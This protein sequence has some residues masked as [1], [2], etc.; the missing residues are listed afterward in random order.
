MAQTPVH[1][2]VA[3][4]IAAIMLDNP[5]LNVLTVD[6][7]ARLDALLRE[8]E[9]DA[10]VKALVVHGAGERAFSAGSDIKEFDA[11]MAPN[12]A[13]ERKLY[14]ENAMYTRLARFPAPTIAAVTGI[15]FGGGLELAVCCDLIVAEANS[16]F[17]LPEVKLGVFPGSGGTVRV[18]RRIGPARAKEMIYFG[19]PIDAAT[20][21][22]WGLINRVAETGKALR[23]AM[24]MARRLA[25]GPESLRHAK[26]AIDMAF[27]MTEAD[28]VS[29]GLPLIDASF[30]SSD[31][32]E[33][34]DAFREKRPPK[35]GGR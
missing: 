8:L 31:C 34:V 15:A 26:Q 20:A 25:D 9:S 4:G 32:R 18:T 7:T 1:C 30:S 28:A 33:G 10:G 2:E 16:R 3:Q 14:T 5:P 11:Y 35:F 21:R 12:A 24:D 17:A 29:R 13:V 23:V 6:M 19:D 22:D 27:D